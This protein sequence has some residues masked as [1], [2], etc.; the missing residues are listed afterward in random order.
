MQLVNHRHAEPNDAQFV[1]AL[2]SHVQQFEVYR[3]QFIYQISTNSLCTQ[4]PRSR[5]LV[6]FVP[7]TPTA[8][9]TTTDIYGPITLLAAA[10]MRGNKAGRSEVALLLCACAQDID[11]AN[12]RRQ[13]GHMSE[14][15][16]KICSI[17]SVQDAQVPT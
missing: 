4:M 6:I 10:C 15:T 13:R 16:T 11:N 3:N 9:E 17:K 1:V 12:T 2:V 5:D 7:T 8:T 14:Q